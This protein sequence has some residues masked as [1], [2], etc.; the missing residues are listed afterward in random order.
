MKVRQGRRKKVA[1]LLVLA[2]DSIYAVMVQKVGK[3]L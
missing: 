1:R 2:K 3:V